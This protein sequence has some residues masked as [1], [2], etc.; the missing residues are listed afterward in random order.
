MEKGALQISSLF[1]LLEDVLRGSLVTAKPLHSDVRLSSYLHGGLECELAV[2]LLH[3]FA[4]KGFV[5][6]TW[7]T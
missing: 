1:H 5:H 3:K 2:V 7:L 6:N 4:H